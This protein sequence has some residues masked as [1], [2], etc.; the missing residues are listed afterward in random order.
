[1][2]ASKIVAAAA[3]GVGGAGLDVDEVFSTFLYDGSSSAQTINNGIDLSGEGGMV[4]IKERSSS[5]SDHGIHDTERGIKNPILANTTDAEN[6]YYNTNN[7]GITAFNN[8]GFTV[9]STHNFNDDGDTAVS[10]TFRKAP[11]FFDIVTYT[12][13]GTAGRQIA[14]NL[15]STVGMLIVKSSSHASSWKVQHRSTG[16][17]NALEL[18]D[19]RG[20]TDVDDAFWN[21]TAASSTH[22]TVGDS[23][24]TNGSGRT[25]VAYLFAHNNSGDGGFGPSGDQDII[26]CGSY[27]GHSSNDIDINLGFE[28]QW[29]LVKRTNSSS[30]PAWW[31]ADVMRGWDSSGIS[32]LEAQ[33]SSAEQ[34]PYG[35]I[36]PTAT[37][38]HIPQGNV[39]NDNSS[40]TYIYMAIRRGSLN[41]PDDAT[42]V[43]AVAARTGASGNQGAY[44]S[45]FPVDMA[46]HKVITNSINPYEIGSRLTQGNSMNTTD[47]SAEVT[48]S[49]QQYDYMDGW[50]SEGSP[51]STKYAW[52]WKR[53]P[54]YFDA[55]AYTGTGSARTI[56]HNLGV[57]P[58]DVGKT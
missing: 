8:N 3:S 36:T 47:N 17:T 20:A 50:N 15:G 9:A 6:S 16:A 19:T 7:L 38:F 54:S 25:Y 30:S 23:T 55:V 46:F 44:R 22:F 37:G 58:D 2:T 57:A 28:P 39:M 24:S 4:W 21:D 41:V 42:K 51:S 49:D 10:W 26:N 35:S 29:L 34:N 33:S 32:R 14:H 12:G 52:M 1:M 43:F 27:T 48:Q 31:M 11:N 40:S 53:A 45:G 18:N 5:G 56:A 13:N